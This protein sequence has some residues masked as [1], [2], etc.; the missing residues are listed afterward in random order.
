VVPV[1]E[2]ADAWPRLAGAVGAAGAVDRR[3]A[4]G[5]GY[6]AVAALVSVTCILLMRETH[7]A[8]LRQERD[9]AVA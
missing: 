1:P 6:V 9:A 5:G 2:S 4:G 8:D 7:H 3:R